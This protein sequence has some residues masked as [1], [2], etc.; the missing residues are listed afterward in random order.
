MKVFLTGATGFL[1]K[2]IQNSLQQN[3][4]EFTALSRKEQRSPNF[5]FG[6]ILH[7]E[8]YKNQLA[9]CDMVIHAAGQVSHLNEDAESMWN[10]HFEG[11]KTLLSV[12]KQADTKRFVY[13]SSSGTVAVS[14]TPDIIAT[15]K[16]PVPLETIRDWPYYRAKYFAEQ[17]VME[18]F[19]DRTICLNPSLLLGPGDD[20]MGS[21]TETIRLFLDGKLPVSPSGGLSF[22]DV[23]DVAKTVVSALDSGTLGQKYLM[24]SANISF[25]EFYKKIARLSNKPAPYF[26]LPKNGHKLLYVFP[27]WKNISSEIRRE[28]LILASHFWYVNSEKAKTELR[29]SPRDPLET[30]SDTLADIREN[31]SRYIPWNK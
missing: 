18:S 19:S 23:R 24:G 8:T 6:D 25:W 10:I 12:M 16:S 28:N 21:S 13:V 7:P 11:T 1:G 14:K 29:F 22:V 17:H 31:Q 9:K 30:L 4:V 3:N 15:E 26:A 20:P 27:K 2:H 5:I